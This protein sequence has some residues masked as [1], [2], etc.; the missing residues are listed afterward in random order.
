MP[1][2]R[3]ARHGSALSSIWRVPRK[4]TPM[5]CSSSAPQE[6]EAWR[7]LTV[8]EAMSPK[9]GRLGRH[10]AI[11]SRGRRIARPFRLLAC[12]FGIFSRQRT[13]WVVC[14]ALGGLAGCSSGNQHRAPEPPAPSA[15]LTLSPGKARPGDRLELSVTE[16]PGRSDTYDVFARLDRRLGANWVPLLTLSAAYADSPPTA[17]PYSPRAPLRGVG[18]TGSGVQ[19]LRV[20]NVPAGRY[21]IVKRIGGTTLTVNL[22]VL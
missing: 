21:R 22:Q 13:T 2:A 9:L 5:A 15:T 7:T 8:R 4:F 16:P 6:N 12:G 1:I 3:C 10:A 19:V 17:V 18:S 20:P 11:E 14:A